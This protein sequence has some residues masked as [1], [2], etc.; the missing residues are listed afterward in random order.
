[1]WVLLDFLKSIFNSFSFPFAHSHVPSRREQ[2]FTEYWVERKRVPTSFVRYY[3]H[4]IVP[5][6]LKT[7]DGPAPTPYFEPASNYNCFQVNYLNL[8]GYPNNNVNARYFSSIFRLLEFR[9][10]L[11]VYLSMENNFTLEWT[12]APSVGSDTT[13][14]GAAISGNPCNISGLVTVW[15]IYDRNGWCKAHGRL[16]TATELFLDNDP[17][18]FLQANNQGVFLVLKQWSVNME[19]YYH[20]SVLLQDTVDLKGLPMGN[21][22][23]ANDNFA[24]DVLDF[25]TL[26]M[27][28]LASDRF[29]AGV[30]EVL[31]GSITWSVAYWDGRGEYDGVC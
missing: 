3:Q 7:S 22:H 6:S 5:F 9:F 23:D 26:F 19:T 1:M 20:S 29:S 31:P 21:A 4:A 14:S 25:G 8:H 13:S 11:W 27:V 16:P 18:S 30:S 28:T 10:S 17:Q 24:A 12:T 2:F 15:L